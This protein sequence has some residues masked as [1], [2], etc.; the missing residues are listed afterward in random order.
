MSTIKKSDFTK[1]INKKFGFSTSM[2]ERLVDVVFDEISEALRRCRRVQ[3][4]NFGAFNINHKRE[5]I[6]RNPKTGKTAVITARRVPTFRPAAEFR[7][8]VKEK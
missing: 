7:A 8:L 5:R 2:S 6:G 3:I 1:Y 4:T